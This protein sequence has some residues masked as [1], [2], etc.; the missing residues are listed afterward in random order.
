MSGS[1]FLTPNTLACCTRIPFPH[2][3]IEGWRS[4][5]IE[6]EGEANSFS[7]EDLGFQVC[8]ET[9]VVSEERARDIIEDICQNIEQKTEQKTEVVQIS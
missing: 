1:I 3:S 4:N 9:G 5:R 2:K 7:D 8:F 6:V